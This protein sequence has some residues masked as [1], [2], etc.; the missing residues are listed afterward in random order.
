LALT[1]FALFTLGLLLY[2][3]RIG[4]ED[5][6]AER[7]ASARLYGFLEER[8]EGLD[9]IRANGAGAYTMRRFYERVRD[10]Y[11]TGRRA[12]KKRTAIWRTIIF[13]FGQGHVLALGMGAYLYYRGLITV[14]TVY[15]LYHYMQMLFQPLEQ[16]AN[17]VQDLQKALA[18][19]GRVQELMARETGIEQEGSLENPPPGALS[20]AFEEVSFSYHRDQPVLEDV[21]FRLEAGEVLG[22][23]GRTG[24]GKTTLAR[25]LFRLYE[26]TAGIIRVGGRPIEAVSLDHLRQ[27]VAMV[28]Q[29]VQLFRASVRDNLTFFDPLIPD[30]RIVAILKELGLDEWYASLPQGLDTELATG[31]EGLSAGEAQLLAFARAFLGDPGLVVLDE[32]SSR[33]DPATEHRLEQAMNRLLEGR[34]SIIIAHRLATLDRVDEIMIM[35]DCHIQEYGPRDE[36]V[37]D[38]ES[39]FHHLLTTGLEEVFA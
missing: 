32:P 15:L 16:I 12:F 29:D 8:L 17:Q 11:Q 7:E 2:L 35:G 21:S 22:L 5:S 19:M 34:T 28:T 3:R 23:L 10:F 18:G 24:S 38:R 33:L 25:L 37:Q 6:K 14:G 26:P 39:L 30:A 13:L 20:V 31:E 9:D 1:A 27:A 4:V 36:L